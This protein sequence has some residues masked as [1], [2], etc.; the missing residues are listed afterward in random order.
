MT[1]ILGDDT[2]A[3]RA[4][5]RSV[6]GPGTQV[7]AGDQIRVT[8]VAEERRSGGPW[9]MGL[10]QIQLLS[11]GPS[12][13][14]VDSV[15]FT[16]Q[17]GQACDAKAWEGT[18]EAT[19]TVP[20]NPPPVVELCVVA[21]DW[22]GNGEDRGSWKCAQFPTGEIWTGTLHGE[23]RN[24]AA[25]GLGPHVVIEGDLVSYH[26]DTVMLTVAPDGSVSG[27]GSSTAVA[28]MGP[29]G[30]YTVTLS[31]TREDDAFRPLR[32]SYSVGGGSADWVVPIR[33]RTAEGT[34]QSTAGT[35][36]YTLTIKL[37][38]VSCEEAVG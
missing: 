31:G 18:L 16:G 24:P 21:D 26:D 10:A 38:C 34:F 33:G 28:P 12:Q 4:R 23:W 13:E 20:P 8:A 27:E 15:D 14:L 6:P 30:S 37:T 22:A 1:V 2:L 17:R 7:K 5:V 3:P 32:V 35:T 9:Q 19:Y 29:P 36:T 11:L 25:A